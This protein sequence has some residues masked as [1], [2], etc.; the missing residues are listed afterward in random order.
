[1][2]A[3][4]IVLEGPGRELLG[5]RQVAERYLGVGRVV[6]AQDESEAARLAARLEQILE[7]GPQ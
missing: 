2:M 6:N 1:M 5:D 7:I 4:H 3:I